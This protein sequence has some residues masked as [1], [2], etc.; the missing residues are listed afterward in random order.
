MGHMPTDRV[1]FGGTSPKPEHWF[2]GDG[3]VPHRPI[4]SGD[5]PIPYVRHASWATC[6]RVGL[7]SPEAS[8]R[9]RRRKCVD[10]APVAAIRDRVSPPLPRTKRDR[11]ESELALPELSSGTRRPSGHTAWLPCKLCSRLPTVAAAALEGV[12]AGVVS[13]SR[14]RVQGCR[15]SLASRIVANSATVCEKCARRPWASP[16]YVPNCGQ[17]GYR[18]RSWFCST[19]ERGPPF[20]RRL[21]SLP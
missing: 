15:L 10:A 18:H 5:F 17:F 19:G 13:G 20:L 9:T 7:G 16:I 1:G 2:P 11:R 21:P 12:V 3:D 8:G 14:F 4:L 6:P